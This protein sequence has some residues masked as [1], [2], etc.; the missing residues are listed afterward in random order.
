MLKL[1]FSGWS[2]LACRILIKYMGPFDV[3]Y[4]IR[5]CV[6]NY[7]VT[8]DLPNANWNTAGFVIL[9]RY[10]K[11][12]EVVVTIP[13][14]FNTYFLVWDGV[15]LSNYTLYLKYVTS[16]KITRIELCL[17]VIYA[18]RKIQMISWKYS[19]RICGLS[20]TFQYNI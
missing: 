20:I 8:D 18:L 2:V 16:G 9:S 1:L 13:W 3:N 14:Y 4:C 12:K 15:F 10:L 11:K 19:E 5:F 6:C 7:K 17:D